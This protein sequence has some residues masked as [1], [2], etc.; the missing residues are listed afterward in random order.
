M[1]FVSKLMVD[2]SK[3]KALTISTA[4]HIRKTSL[5][6]HPTFDPQQG[7]QKQN[8]ARYLHANIVTRWLITSHWAINEQ[9]IVWLTRDFLTNN[10]FV[11]L[12]LKLFV[13]SSDWSTDWRSDWPFEHQLI[14]W[15]INWPRERKSNE[16]VK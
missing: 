15:P 8:F 5:L 14:H 13:W 11:G 7:W 16:K 2:E 10:S 6:P 3:A 12:A 1:R 9:Q 4:I